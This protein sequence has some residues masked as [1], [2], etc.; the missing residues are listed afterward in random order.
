MDLDP[1]KETGINVKLLDRAITAVEH[2]APSLKFV[3]LPTGTKV[4]SAP[5]PR[6]DSH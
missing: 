2:L 6:N 5:A 4:C 3:V 1:A